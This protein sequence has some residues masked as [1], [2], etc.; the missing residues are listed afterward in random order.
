MRHEGSA[1]V[2]MRASVGQVARLTVEE[3]HEGCIPFA[4][5]RPSLCSRWAQE[6]AGIAPRTA[7]VPSAGTCSR[8]L[9]NRAWEASCGLRLNA[10][11][12]S[13]TGG[14]MPRVMA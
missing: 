4:D 1:I 12:S 10:T 8:E 6:M 13:P 11:L 9:G 3:P 2:A 5:Y 14:V 7:K